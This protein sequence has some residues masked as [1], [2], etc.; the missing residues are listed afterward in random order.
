[1]PSAMGIC[2][3]RERACGSVDCT[4][5]LGG[6]VVVARGVCSRTSLGRASAM[7]GHAPSVLSVASVR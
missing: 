4:L 1:M 5:K 2:G 6:G 3:V 7:V